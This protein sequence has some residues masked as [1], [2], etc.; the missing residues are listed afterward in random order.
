MPL[1]SSITLPVELFPLLNRD[2]PES[3]LPP[4]LPQ[5]P[6]S[7]THKSTISTITPNLPIP[8]IAILHLLNDDLSSAHTLVQEDDTNID[9][10]LIHSILH[11]RE[12]DFWNS[13]WWLDQFSHPFLDQLY[14]Q[15][16]LQGKKGAKQF[17]DMIQRLTS[18]K[19]AITA[20]AAQRDVNEAKKWQWEEHSS[21]VQYLF[22][23][24]DVA[25]LAS[26]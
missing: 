1:S 16:N 11:R 21:L 13:K 20:C 22:K 2:Q 26:A 25:P 10:N 3:Q 5:K 24:Y 14:K 4:L 19:G 8:I 6:F 23:K 18:N 12:A 15:R 17:V 9:S 7:P